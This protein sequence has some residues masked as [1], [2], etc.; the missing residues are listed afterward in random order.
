MKNFITAL[1]FVG[2]TSVVMAAPACIP[3]G[4]VTSLNPGGCT[5]N[6]LLFQNFALTPA[7]GSF[8]GAGPLAVLV[9]TTAN[10]NVLLDTN[11]NQGNTGGLQRLFFTFDVSTLDPFA[12]IV[13]ASTANG[14]SVGTSIRQVVCAGAITLTTGACGGTLLQDVTNAGGTATPNTAFAGVT[15]LS[16]WREMITPINTTITGASVDFQATPEPVAFALMG[17]GLCAL[18]L[19]QRRRKSKS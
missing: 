13:G 15:S 17:S 11:P 10:G 2:I 4:D 9:I 5:A 16:V 6:G 3:V 8:P 12:L 18:A 1:L 14:G 7:L 19:I